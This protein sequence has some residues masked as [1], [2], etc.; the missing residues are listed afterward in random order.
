MAN[1]R[2]RVIEPGPAPG[3]RLCSLAGFRVLNKK[4]AWSHPSL[5]SVRTAYCHDVNILTYFS[6]SKEGP[7]HSSTRTSCFSSPELTSW[8]MTYDCDASLV[9]SLWF[10]DQSRTPCSIHSS[11]SPSSPI[12]WIS[13]SLLVSWRGFLKSSAPFFIHCH[14]VWAYVM[15]HDWG[16]AFGR[17][18]LGKWSCTLLSTYQEA[19]DISR[20]CWWC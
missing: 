8:L 18:T 20:Y 16:Y 10:Q 5:A 6:L 13:Q 2:R 17:K 9:L 4:V 15:S 12:W 11:W 19:P 3:S 1:F 7:S 14:S